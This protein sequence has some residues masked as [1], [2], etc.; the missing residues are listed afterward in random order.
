MEEKERIAVLETEIKY[1]R[2]D[3][4]DMKSKVE[5]TN[6]LLASLSGQLVK[7][8]DFNSLCVRVEENEKVIAR[9]K[10][11]VTIG[12]TVASAIISFVIWIGD[13]IWDFWIKK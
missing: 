11:Y 3:I 10:I 1:V 8:S 7:T 6:T 2:D 12:V 13:K 9:A 4:K 5:T